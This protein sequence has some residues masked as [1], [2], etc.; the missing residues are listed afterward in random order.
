MSELS[1]SNNPRVRR[2]YAHVMLGKLANGEVNVETAQ[3]AIHRADQT[4]RGDASN[5]PWRLIRA[6]EK[7][8][9]KRLREARQA[10]DEALR[11]AIPKQNDVFAGMLNG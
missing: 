2:A 3:A 10:Y 4:R 6:K 7:G 8:A 9:E 5:F 1:Q 11:I